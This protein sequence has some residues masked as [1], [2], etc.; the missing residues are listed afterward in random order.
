MVG[1]GVLQKSG[2]TALNG[3]R[4]VL[5]QVRGRDGD[6]LLAFFPL[7]ESNRTGQRGGGSNAGVR[8]ANTRYYLGAET[9]PLIPTVRGTK[10]KEGE[11]VGR[12]NAQLPRPICGRGRGRVRHVVVIVVGG[13]GELER[14]C[15]RSLAVAALLALCGNVIRGG[16]QGSTGSGEN[17]PAHATPSGSSPNALTGRARR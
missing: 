15:R 13:G 11:G 1:D 5:A 8:K 4:R 6:R 14:E 12:D 17:V 7:L 2:L 10:R 9:S 3:R 16:Y